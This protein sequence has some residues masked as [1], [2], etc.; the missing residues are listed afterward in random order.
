MLTR[1]LA[2]GLSSE[3]DLRIVAPSLVTVKVPFVVDSNGQLVSPKASGS[4]SLRRILFM[5]WDMSAD[6]T[7]TFFRRTYLGS[8]RRLDQVSKSHRSDERRQ[9]SILPPLLRCLQVQS[10]FGTSRRMARDTEI[11]SALTSSA[12][13][14]IMIPSLLS[15]IRSNRFYE[16]SRNECRK[17]LYRLV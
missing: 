8:E 15:S 12:Q 13:M 10:R 7:L 14:F 11:A 17:F 1:I 4:P 3:M 5:P 9:T 6:F 2:A 16:R